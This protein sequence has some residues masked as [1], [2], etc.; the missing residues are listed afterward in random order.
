MIRHYLSRNR[1]LTAVLVAFLVLGA[2]YSIATPLFEAP[3]EV[4]H[5]FHV[6][7]IADGKGLPVLLPEGEALYAQ[8]G[9][10]PSLYYLL[11]AMASF[12]I[13]TGNADDLLQY[14]P[15]V[16]VGIPSLVGNKNVILHATREAFP[17]RGAVLAVHLLRWLSVLFG[18]LTIL[19][20]YLVALEVIPGQRALALGAAAITAFNPQF[21]FTTSTV[22]NDGLLV[23]LCSLAVFFSVLILT[24]GPS[25]WRWVGVGFT[26][27]LAALTK[28]TGVGLLAPVL[29]V[30]AI[31][32][33][34]RSRRAAMEGAIIVVGLVAI[35]AGW[36]YMR[37]WFLY[38][39]IT[40][41]S[42]FFE[43]LGAP[44]GRRLTLDQFVGELEGFRLSYWAVFGW[45]NVLAGRWVYRFFDLLVLLGLI[46]LPLAATRVLR[47]RE[48]LS[49]AP[50]LVVVV[51]IMTVVVGYVR[52]NQLIDAATGRLVFPA[53][54]GLSTLLAWGLVQFP[55]RR[56]RLTFVYGLGATMFVVALA[57]P[58]LYIR[59]TYARPPTVTSDR[60]PALPN[61]TKVSF[62]D[63]MELVGYELEGGAFHPG[64]FVHA[65]L[66][67]Q[68]LTRMERDYS[69]SLV[70]LTPSGDLVGQEDSYPGL[71]SYPTSH[72]EV[73]EVIADRCWVRVKPRT[74]VPAVAWLL[75]NVYYLPTMEQVPALSNGEPSQQVLLG[76]LKIAPWEAEEYAISNPMRANFG[77]QIDLIGYDLD[78]REVRAGDTLELTLYW[79]ARARANEDYTVFAHV[80]DE[81]GRIW[82]QDDSH[83]V[84]GDY[85]TSFWEAQEV[86]ADTYTLTVPGDMP[87]GEYELEVGLYLASS[88]ERLPILDEEGQVLDNRVIVS[89]LAVLE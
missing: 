86:V 24:R 45:F 27:G 88:L 10:Q 81:E 62:D 25:R 8:E 38:E 7:H 59:P 23:A 64:E 32:A 53:I 85:P 50:G 31:I 1:A 26:V 33:V 17:Y 70:L 56:H 77:N 13:D 71:G 16:N 15:Y 28:L 46:G 12:W 42:R 47:R 52:Y 21:I 83:P 84:R 19:A 51:W 29:V 18:V 66:Y 44:P 41:M 3:D 79:Q 74:Q 48:H 6:K 49:V 4:Q 65:T 34:R 63:Q 36:W 76:R 54:A 75:V 58:F 55:P 35:V 20:T 68:G 78:T 67:W 82:A 87:P 80:V 9:G 73:G 60:L 5:F 11:G 22:N 30:V 2:V 72:W 40:G 37:N 89:T 57:C 14:N 69:V 43:A 61:R 39:D